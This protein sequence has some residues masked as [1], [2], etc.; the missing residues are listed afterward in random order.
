MN[1]L[2]IVG[3]LGDEWWAGGVALGELERLIPSRT[4]NL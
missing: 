2:I 1:K 4:T 3:G